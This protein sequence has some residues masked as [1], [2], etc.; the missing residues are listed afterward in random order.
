MRARRGL[1]AISLL[2]PPSP[3]PSC[4][5][6]GHSHT[7]APVDGGYGTHVHHELREEEYVSH[8]AGGA[9]A[10]HRLALGE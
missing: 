7:D 8:E 4:N 10:A 2:T 1:D 6:S 3:R 9:V 5:H